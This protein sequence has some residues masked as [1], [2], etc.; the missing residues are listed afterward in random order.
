M[1]IYIKISALPTRKEVNS[2]AEYLYSLG[3][4]NCYWSQGHADSNNKP[5]SLVVGIK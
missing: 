4:S 5:M 2:A 1:K 3:C